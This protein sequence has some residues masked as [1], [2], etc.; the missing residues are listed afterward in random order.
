MSSSE[1]ALGASL[2]FDLTITLPAVESTLSTYQSSV[3][4]FFTIEN[5][6]QAN[7]L[8]VEDNYGHKLHTLKPYTGAVFQA[9]T[10][11]ISTADGYSGDQQWRLTGG[12]LMP[13]G[14]G[15]SNNK[16]CCLKTSTVWLPMD[17][18]C[19]IPDVS[20]LATE[21]TSL[22][23]A[24]FSSA[25]D[26]TALVAGMEYVLGQLASMHSC[27]F[28]YINH[29]HNMMMEVTGAFDLVTFTT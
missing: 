3:G 28:D 15:F 7:Y 14:E 6:A 11:E 17:I 27:A 29:I 10:T 8:Y 24:T 18:T 5:R 12:H 9:V 22:S 4:N 16:S 13:G 1:G 26:S 20:C 25:T 2:D 19:Y 21:I 23:T